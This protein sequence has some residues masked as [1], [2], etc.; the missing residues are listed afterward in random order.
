MNTIPFTRREFLLS[1]AGLAV[2][3]VLPGLSGT[4]LAAGTATGDTLVSVFLRGAM[5][6]LHALVPFGDPNYYTRRPTLAVPP[7]GSASGALDLDGFFGLHPALEPLLPLYEAGLL[8]FVHATGSPD[9]SHSHFDAQDYMDL[10][11]PGENATADGWI[12][13]HLETKAGGGSVF[14]GVAIGPLVPLSLLGQVPAVA[15]ADVKNFGLWNTSPGF[16][17]T[18][19]TLYLG[20]DAL[21]ETGQ[22]TLAAIAELKAANPGGYQAENGA[23]Y[24]AGGVGT[25]LLQTAQLI[26]SS[27]RPEAITLDLGGWDTHQGQA[28]ILQ[29]L[30]AELAAGLAAFCTDLGR[31]MESVIVVVMTEFGRR[32]TQ[33]GTGGTDHGHG[34][35]MMLLGGGVNGGQVYGA[36]PGLGDHQLYGPGDLQITTDYRTL[37]AEVIDKRLDNP[38]VD[39]V[40]PGFALPAYLGVCV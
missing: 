27:L 13:R 7:P 18:L 3:C 1:S 6:G 9:D 34:S 35:C 20:S 17:N 24:P 4:A 39:Q 16:A 29:N 19:R 14:R 36:W 37:L 21:E 12:G 38:R 26:K 10:G 8:A 33:N 15:V 11:T 2:P 32:V 31:R 23:Q 40:F 25:T 5:D 30:F 22:E 28:A